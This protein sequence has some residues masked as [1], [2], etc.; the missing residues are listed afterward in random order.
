[1]A[2]L[3]SQSEFSPLIQEYASYKATFQ[4]CSQKTV[5]EYLLDL[6][7]FFR[8]LIA[9]E[10]GIDPISDDFYEIDVS[11]FGLE[12]LGRVKTEDIFAFL[13]YANKERGNQWAARSRKLSSIR[14][15]YKYLVSKRHYLDFNPSANLDTPKTKRALPKVLTL[16]ESERLL[17]AV[18]GDSDSPYRIRDYAILTLFLN[19]GM[20]VSELVGINLSD[21][22]SDFRSVR[23]TGKGNKERIVYLNEACQT[24]LMA[25]VIERKSPKYA[26]V[27]DRALFL[28]RL[29]KRI[30]VKTVQ[31][32]VYKYLDHAGLAAK[33]YSVHKLRHTAA[34]L[35][36]QS[37]NV[38]VRVLKD[39]L[40]HEQLNTTQIYT[41][42]SNRNM[43]DAMAQNP[44]AARKKAKK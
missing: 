27:R 24:S 30:S 22:D 7:T 12:E 31:A 1:M 23:V 16:E 34:T 44:L 35:M 38:D 17:D 15:L 8:F 37:G 26:T 41:H 39:I 20:R 42:V 25:Y 19:C 14:S 43:E 32:M 40:G 5:E 4:G 29:E 18:E 6:R 3:I 9:K 28:S 2:E 11:S 36:Y 21:I 33:H 13:L 10:K